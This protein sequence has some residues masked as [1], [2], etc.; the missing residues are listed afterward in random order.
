MITHTLT[1]ATDTRTVHAST[2]Q[3]PPP[4]PSADVVR[5]VA[6]DDDTFLE[7]DCARYVPR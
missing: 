2:T 7:H 3:V 6:A 5:F 4:T 1:A